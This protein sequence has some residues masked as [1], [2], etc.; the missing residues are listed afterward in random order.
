MEIISGLVRGRA[1]KR[2]KWILYSVFMFWLVS[3]CITV[4]YAEEP[5]TEE[6]E[7]EKI[8]LAEPSVDTDEESPSSSNEETIICENTAD[9]ISAENSEEEMSV[10]NTTGEV[11]AVSE[12]VDDNNV[13]SDQE[14]VSL[15]EEKTDFSTLEEYSE[16]P[17]E[18]ISQETVDYSE[19]VIAG[20]TVFRTVENPATEEVLLSGFVTV[21]DQVRYYDPETNVFVTGEVTIDGFTYYFDDETGEMVTGWQ[22]NPGNNNTV[23]Y[24]DLGHRLYGFQEINEMQYYFDPLSGAM[25]KNQKKIGDYYYYFDIDTGVMVTGWKDIAEQKKRV[26]YNNDGHMVYGLQDIENE[27]YYFD[28]YTGAMQKDQKKINNYYYFFDKETGVMITGWKD[29]PEQKKR[30]YYNSEGHMIYGLQGIEDARYYFDPYTGAMQKDQKKINGYYYFFDKE[31]G[32]MVTGWK[33]I[34][35][36]KKRVYYNGE[37]HMLYGFQNIDGSRYYFDPYTGAMQKDQKKINGYYYFFDKETGVMITGWKDLPEQKKR[38]YYD[39]EGRMLHGL[40]TIGDGKYYFDPYTGAMQKDQKKINGYYYF[41]DKETGVMVTGW[42]DIPEQKKRVYYNSE[43][44]MVYGNYSIDNVVY[45]F[46]NG[47]G[48]LIGNFKDVNGG[49]QFVYKNGSLASGQTKLN[50]NYYYFDEQTHMMVTGFKTIKSQN[51]TVFY[52]SNGIMKHGSFMYDGRT[53]LADKYTGAIKKGPSNGIRYYSQL[54][55]SWAYRY[56]GRWMVASSGCGVSSIAMALSSLNNSTID[57]I[58]VANYLYGIGEYNNSGYGVA[59]STGSAN[60][61]AAS[62]WDTECDHITSYN[63]L[64]EYLKGGLIVLGIVGPGDFCPSGVTH[65]ILL[66][67]YSDGDTRVYDPLGNRASGWHSVGS[68]WAQQS[69]HW[70]DTDAGTPFFA[71]YTY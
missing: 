59:G 10:E 8:T 17:V 53:Y 49:K 54:D 37:G 25:Q 61:A 67:G 50:N 1:M 41:F 40:H 42:K 64:V 71:F 63:E 7:Q 18:V 45:V 46:E 19:P 27:R 32:V 43:G 48:A 31:T 70:M 12:P 65:E 3:F 26:Y 36:Q 57:P 15:T 23:Y 21:D 51:K 22:S 6:A 56:Y 5:E 35:E 13:F 28:P 44:H 68:V 39:S 29:I 24:D 55:S 33:D 60:P 47:T 11:I 9:K 2:C 58:D 16:A 4:V 20:N 62:H 69:S 52:D 30:V 34:P 66:Y 38:V 14:T